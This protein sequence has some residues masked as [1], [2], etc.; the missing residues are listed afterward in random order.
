MSEFLER[1]LHVVRI[2]SHAEAAAPSDV[3]FTLDGTTITVTWTPPSP[4]P[5][6]GYIVYY[7]DF[8]SPSHYPVA[9]DEGNVSV[10]SGSDSRVVI[11]VT[12]IV[13]TVSVVAVSDLPSAEVE[14][15]PGTHRYMLPLFM[16]TKLYK[17]ACDVTAC[18]FSDPYVEILGQVLLPDHS[19]VDN[20]VM[21]L[22]CI[23]GRVDCCTSANTKWYLPSGVAASSA[24]TASYG[25]GSNRG[26]IEL[27]TGGAASLNQGIHRCTLPESD[28]AANPS[29][30]SLY[31]GIYNPG[32]G[33]CITH[34]ITGL[35][36]VCSK[37]Y[38]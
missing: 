18:L 21:R 28:H 37:L 30:I 13:Y 34:L 24:T 2:N 20:T 3:R 33:E 38:Y 16:I 31:V 9:R 7:V 35:K 32:Q 14:G 6:N 11:P 23:T 36:V 22:R 10:S 5:S 12:D 8:Y 26:A 1:V 19:L 25:G 27:V 4:A 29:T 15:V 17:C